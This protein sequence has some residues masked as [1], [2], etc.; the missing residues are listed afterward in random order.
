MWSLHNWIPIKWLF[1]FF[2]CW[3]ELKLNSRNK[4][5][6][7]K[8]SE[9]SR[10]WYS[11]Y[12][13]TWTYINKVFTNISVLFCTL[14]FFLKRIYA[15]F[16]ILTNVWTQNLWTNYKIQTAT[17][18]KIMLTK[19][20]YVALYILCSSSECDTC[21]NYCFMNNFDMQLTST[22]CILIL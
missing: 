16:C 5:N 22:D 6:E 12:K 20:K 9:Q 11:M 7:K 1:F 3:V 15:V 2:F 10:W 4:M 8:N 14:S 19:R 17:I 21:F 18:T 13:W